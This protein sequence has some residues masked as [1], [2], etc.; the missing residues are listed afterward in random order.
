MHPA[1]LFIVAT[2][3]GQAEDLSPRAQAILQASDWVL[4]EDTRKTGQLLAQLGLDC[5]LTA[6]HEHNEHQRVEQIL[7]WLAQGKQLALVSD[8]G[9]PLISDPGFVLVRAVRAAGY[10]VRP[11]PGPCALIAGL[12][13]S[14]LP[15]D[16][17]MFEGFLPAKTGAR[18]ERLQSVADSDATLVFYESRHRILACLA[19]M[20]LVFGHDRPMV[21]A[22]E[23]TKTYETIQQGSIADILAWLEADAQQ[24]RGE[25]VLMVAGRAKP[26]GEQDDAQTRLWLQ[27]L[28][29]ELPPSQAAQI[30][31]QVLGGKKR[32]WYQKIEQWRN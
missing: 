26:Q 11:V 8:A 22:R 28:A 20:A 1:T 16:R 19:D 13:V 5:R 18:Q 17:F 15:T 7:G 12:S 31:A 23:L 30:A 21:L 2:P 25:M 9:T 24:Q 29:K 3:I 27:V 6:L 10:S 32:D 4:A 14:G